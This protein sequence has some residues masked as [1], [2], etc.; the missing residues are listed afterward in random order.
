MTH[1]GA[2]LPVPP[3][4][5]DESGSHLPEPVVSPMGALGQRLREVREDRGLSLRQLARQLGVSPSFVSQMETGKSQPSVATLYSLSQLLG[6]SIDRLFVSE[7]ALA[8][9]APAGDPTDDDTDDDTHDT[10]DDT[11]DHTDDEVVGTAD[12]PVVSRVHLGSPVD[13][14]PGQ[15]VPERLSVTRPG[16]RARL[17]MDSG[18]IWEQLATNTG[19]HLE[20]IEIVYP[21]G[22]SSTT[23]G[24]MLRHLGYECGY[25]MEGELEVTVGFDVFTLRAGEALGLDSATPHLFT[26]RGEI[27]A[28]GVWFVRH[29]HP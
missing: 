14:W 16:E 28:R 3:A 29:S 1:D 8:G 15:G 4:E 24:R 7:A 10:D 9:A 13:A 17:V 22:S 11:D 23:D 25:L 6:V 19:S 20:F 18:V 27:P 26:N 5:P 21:P 12:A 2:S